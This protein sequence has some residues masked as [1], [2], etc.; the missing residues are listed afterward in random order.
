M[1][2]PPHRTTLGRAQI[3]QLQWCLM[4]A[5][6]RGVLI[7]KHPNQAIVDAGGVGYEVII[8]VSTYPHFL[9]T[10]NEVRLRIHTHLRGILARKA[11]RN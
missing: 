9:E 4:I 6:L 8:P 3:R 7:E 11:A 1:D 5:I 10:G 2:L